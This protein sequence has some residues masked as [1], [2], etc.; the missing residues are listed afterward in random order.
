MRRQLLKHHRTAAIS[1]RD[2]VGESP[3]LTDC[4]RTAQQYA[5]V[6]SPI[7]IYGQSGTGKEMFVQSIHNASQRKNGPFVVSNFAAL[8]ENLIESEL[9]GYEKGAFTGA[10]SN[11]K[12]GLF[13]QGHQGTVF[14]DEVSE[15]PLSVQAR[16]LRVLQEHEV[17]PVGSLKEMCIRDSMV[18]GDPWLHLH[19]KP[20]GRVGGL[21]PI[22]AL[23]RAVDGLNGV[24]HCLVVQSPAIPID[25]LLY[26]SR[27]V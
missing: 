9:F 13:V 3:A 15:M 26:T 27:W 2:I 24:E 25:C 14:L 23:L 8:P 19:N 18:I 21:H 20:E 22:G 10:L 12:Q 6:D 4:I 16:F 5:R 7:L 17:M 11:G 1:F